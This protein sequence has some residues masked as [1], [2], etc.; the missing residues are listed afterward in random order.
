MRVPLKGKS[1]SSQW[2]PVAYEL[3]AQRLGGELGP[4]SVKKIY[5]RLRSKVRPT[6]TSELLDLMSLY[7]GGFSVGPAEDEAGSVDKRWRNRWPDPKP[8]D[9]S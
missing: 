6:P 1:S 8:E 9:L 5:D 7:L 3:V 2:R 4:D